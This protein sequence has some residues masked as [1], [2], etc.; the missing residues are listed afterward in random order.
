MEIRGHLFRV[1]RNHYGIRTAAIANKL[2]RDSHVYKNT[3]TGK[4]IHM[5]NQDML[6]NSIIIRVLADLANITVEELEKTAA[7]LEPDIELLYK[8]RLGLEF[9]N[10]K[11]RKI[12]EKAFYRVDEGFL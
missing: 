6:I 10:R 5:E 1:I 8:D 12:S 7:I 9:K 3:S 2:N 11:P 4:L